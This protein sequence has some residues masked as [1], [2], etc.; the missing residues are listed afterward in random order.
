MGRVCVQKGKELLTRREELDPSRWN[1]S[2]TRS[3][4]GTSTSDS[5]EMHTCRCNSQHNL[6]FPGSG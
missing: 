6:R 2:N 4:S 3:V 1:A 5:V